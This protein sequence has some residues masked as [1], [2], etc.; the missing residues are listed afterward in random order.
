MRVQGKRCQ[1]W[2]RDYVSWLVQ[3]GIF[4]ERANMVPDEAKAALGEET[5]Q[6]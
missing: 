6:N 3:R 2:V 5:R 4:P 1:E